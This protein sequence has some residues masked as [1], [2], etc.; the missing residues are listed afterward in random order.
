MMMVEVT[1][2]AIRLESMAARLDRVKT[3]GMRRP[4]TGPVRSPL[5]RL[6]YRVAPGRTGV[7]GVNMTS[8]DARLRVVGESGFPLGVE[9]D[10]TGERMIVTTSGN[11]LADWA[12]D[13]IR[14][15]PT[16]TGFRIDAE[17]EAV[18]LN[19]TDIERFA[20]EIGPYVIEL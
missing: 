18:I 2:G 6:R 1:V 19:V 8:F 11:K 12:L 13:E 9:V 20:A 16:P 5:A 7:T 3:R 17:G 10:L 4:P 15:A 14:I